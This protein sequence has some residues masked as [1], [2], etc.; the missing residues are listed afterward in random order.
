LAIWRCVG[1]LEA[2]ARRR[3][4]PVRVKRTLL[5]VSIF[6][7]LVPLLVLAFTI[8]VK[9]NNALVRLGVPDV[10]AVT[11]PL[12]AWIAVGIATSMAVVLF[13]SVRTARDVMRG[14]HEMLEGMHRVERN[15]FDVSLLPTDASEFAPL[16][17][18][19]NAM[20]SRLR[21]SIELQDKRLAELTSLHQ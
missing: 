11:E 7:V 1:E 14:A 4:I 13:M 6:V 17:E 21:H 5:F 16:Y 10:A 19:F 8:M 15:E 20:V 9:T 12:Y 18:G 2:E 3:I